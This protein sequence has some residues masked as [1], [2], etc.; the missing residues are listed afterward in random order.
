MNIYRLA[1]GLTI[2]LLLV[3]SL[4][5]VMIYTEIKGLGNHDDDF[6]QNVEKNQNVKSDGG[7]LNNIAQNDVAI[8]Q[9]SEILNRPLFVQGRMP[10]E[11]EKIENISAPV[12]SPLRL[13]LEGVVLSPESRV[14]V[15][16]DLST[17]EIIR[18]GVGISHN[19]WRVQSIEPQT[20]EFERNGEVQSINIELANEP[21]ENTGKPPERRLPINRKRPPPPPR[22]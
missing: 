3:C 4:L 1:N 8:S 21:K 7:I 6:D 2:V 5:A 13:S 9:F 14:A 11:E 18:L 22:K 15:V 17:N 19:G 10:Y 20:V 12:M 16:K